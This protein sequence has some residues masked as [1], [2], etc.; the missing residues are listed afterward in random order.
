MWWPAPAIQ[1]FGW[2]FFG[3]TPNRSISSL[4]HDES[5]RL[6]GLV[7]LLRWIHFKTKKHKKLFF[8]SIPCEGIRI[9]SVTVSVR[10]KL[11]P[12][13]CKCVFCYTTLPIIKILYFSGGYVSSSTQNHCRLP[14]H[15]DSTRKIYIC[16]Q[17]TAWI[18]RIIAS[19]TKFVLFGR[20]FNFL[21]RIC[22]HFVFFTLF[23]CHF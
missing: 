8:L 15:Y 18:R 11:S 20:F 7:H 10:S 12:I 13:A 2:I 4:P 5:P 9:W 1:C 21:S 22:F 19:F 23:R 16:D 6:R 14:N 3:I 17:F